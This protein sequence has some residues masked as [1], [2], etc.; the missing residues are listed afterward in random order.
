[1]TLAA[2]HKKHNKLKGLVNAVLRKVAAT[3]V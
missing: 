3:G 2:K 1:V